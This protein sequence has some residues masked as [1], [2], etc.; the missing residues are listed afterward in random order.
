MILVILFEGQYIRFYQF[1][2]NPHDLELKKSSVIDLNEKEIY[3]DDVYDL[4]K[5]ET[6]V[7]DEVKKQKYPRKNVKILLNNR[8]LILR[9]LSVPMGNE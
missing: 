5:L 1:S 7:R 6:I 9:E 8:Q 2:D 4:T 3:N